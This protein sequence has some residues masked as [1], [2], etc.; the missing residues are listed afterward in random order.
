MYVIIYFHDKGVIT[1]LVITDEY[2]S[3]YLMSNDSFK[4]FAY[5]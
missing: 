1:P 4:I 5:S 3:K 2:L